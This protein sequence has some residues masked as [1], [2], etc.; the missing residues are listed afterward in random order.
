M[1]S[2]LTGHP[3]AAI[4]DTV[5]DIHCRILVSAVT[6]HNRFL[7]KRPNEKVVCTFIAVNVWFYTIF[8]QMFNVDLSIDFKYRSLT[9]TT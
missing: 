8:N 7:R 9:H 3:R 2:D 5:L 6:E 1:P 4:L